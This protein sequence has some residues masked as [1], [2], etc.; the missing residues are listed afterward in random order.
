M[1]TRRRQFHDKALL[2]LFSL[3]VESDMNREEIGFVSGGVKVAIFAR[4]GLSRV[5]H[6]GRER[7]V[8]GIGS[9]TLSGTLTW[10]GDWVYW[11][12]DDIEQS[13][14]KASITLDDDAVIHMS[15]QVATSLGPGGFRRIV[16][17]KKGSKIGKEDAPVNWPVVTSPRFETT[18]PRYRWIAEYQC[19]GYGLVQIIQS[20]V[21]RLTYDVYAMT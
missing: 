11:R 9:K 12:E 2:Y 1:Q 14:V 4:P 13:E 15:Y 10:G 8:P 7:T 3:D 20:E 17:E 19:I 5:Y 18:D 21:R 16:S 6:L